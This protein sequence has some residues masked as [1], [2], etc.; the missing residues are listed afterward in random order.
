MSKKYISVGDRFATVII[1]EN[2]NIVVKE[3]KAEEALAATVEDIVLSDA[4]EFN[5]TILQEVV[6]S[7]R[8]SLK[9]TLE[10]NLK[11]TTLKL[12]GF[13]QSWSAEDRWEVDHCNGRISI[14]SEMLSEEVKD[15]IF[16]IDIK[17]D[18]SG[19]TDKEVKELQSAT[20]RD[21]K[22]AY[23]RKVRDLVYKEAGALATEHVNAVMKECLQDKVKTIAEHLLSQVIKK[24]S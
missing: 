19:L 12:L 21:F 24:T 5:V 2:G 18:W 3:V 22:E 13:S 20:H 11:G 1:D 15:R 9:Q 6:D 16:N 14:L 23:N 8:T 7:A 4:E 17:K 10:K